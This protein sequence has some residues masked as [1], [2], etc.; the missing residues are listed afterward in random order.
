M[1][2]LTKTELASLIATRLCHDLAGPVSAINNGLEFTLME[3][4]Q[5]VEQQSIELLQ[6]SAMEAMAKL[7]LLRMA[8]GLA[9]AGHQAS[10]EEI[11][12]IF[13][14]YTKNMPLE[15]VWPAE[16]MGGFPESIPM[17][18]RRVLALLLLVMS[19]LYVYG[20]ALKLTYTKADDGVEY[21][22]H[23]SHERCKEDTTLLDVVCGQGADVVPSPQLAPALLLGL[24]AEE[25]GWQITHEARSE[26]N[27]AILIISAAIKYCI[28]Q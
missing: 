19:Q 22:F 4:Q 6:L 16:D 12:E 17:R 20:G 21:Q 24:L 8:T 15:L 7:Q 27:T 28:R 1:T 26:D 13:M 11:R 25:E 14:R 9:A 2:E 10:V 18:E 3:G 5:A 23:A